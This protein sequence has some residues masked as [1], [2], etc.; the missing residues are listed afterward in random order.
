M[1]VTCIFFICYLNGN[2]KQKFWPWSKLF[3][4]NTFYYSTTTTTIT[5]FF[6]SINQSIQLPATIV[7]IFPKVHFFR[8]YEQIYFLKFQGKRFL[9]VLRVP[10]SLNNPVYFLHQFC[11]GTNRFLQR[12]QCVPYLKHIL[13]SNLISQVVF[14][15]LSLYKL[16]ASQ[17]ISNRIGQ[18][19]RVMSSQF[20][21][22]LTDFPRIVY[23]NRILDHQNFD[24]I[25]SY[26]PF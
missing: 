19:Y 17:S 2:N 10:P 24:K 7:K 22:L 4:F 6:K 14:S 23:R 8:L 15:H 18:K 13:S 25:T 12:W 11:L 20:S 1:C 9:R 3:N 26:L 21:N 16:S 5:I